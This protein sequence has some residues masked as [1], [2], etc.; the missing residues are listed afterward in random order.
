MPNQHDIKHGDTMPSTLVIE[1]GASRITDSFKFLHHCLPD[2]T[3]SN[4][5]CIVKLP[6]NYS[7]QFKVALMHHQMNSKSFN[8]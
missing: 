4:T 3:I 8:N 7:T 5:D 6:K 1:S 2:P